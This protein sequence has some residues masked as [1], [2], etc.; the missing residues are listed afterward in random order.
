MLV[1]KLIMIKYISVDYVA[2]DNSK[3]HL[4]IF[5]ED[6]EGKKRRRRWE[7]ASNDTPGVPTPSKVTRG[8]RNDRRKRENRSL[9]NKKS[10][11]TAD[12]VQKRRK[13]GREVSYRRLADNPS[14][15]PRRA[16]PPP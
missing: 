13:I 16:S 12:W 5:G 7:R 15:G 1:L 8:A 2:F 6:Y 14:A 9:S 4:N 10:I 11:R 3:Y